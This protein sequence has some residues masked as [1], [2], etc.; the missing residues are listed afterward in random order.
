MSRDGR[1]KVSE[2]YTLTIDQYTVVVMGYFCS[3]LDT[4]CKIFG[5]ST[6]QV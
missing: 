6:L 1:A 4:V 5:L 2:T 3:L